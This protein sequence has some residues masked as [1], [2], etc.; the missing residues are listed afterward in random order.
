MLFIYC[1][2]KINHIL[3]VCRQIVGEFCSQ[4]CMFQRIKLGKV[5]PSLQVYTKLIINICGMSDEIS[6]N[7]S[8]LFLK[9]CLKPFLITSVIHCINVET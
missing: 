6:S 9:N 1:F 2:L 7:M 5:D 4:E 3:C 8:S